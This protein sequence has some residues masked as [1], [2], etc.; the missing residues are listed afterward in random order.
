MRNRRLTVGHKT[1]RV[2]HKEVPI[3]LDDFGI[4][5][6]GGV[7]ISHYIIAKFP[8]ADEITCPTCWDNDCC[9]GR[10]HTCE[11]EMIYDGE[12]AFSS[13]NRSCELMRYKNYSWHFVQSIGCQRKL[14]AV[15]RS[16]I[17]APHL[18]FIL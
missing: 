7:K 6:W 12:E 10:M 2:K 14:N 4:A 11:Q 5:R 8:V 17:L 15:A 18:I 13:V 9:L 1:L 3:C 16:P